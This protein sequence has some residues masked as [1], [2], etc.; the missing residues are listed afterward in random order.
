[1]VKLE[2]LKRLGYKDYVIDKWVK[3][4]YIYIEDSLVTIIDSDTYHKIMTKIL[5]GDLELFDEFVDET[6]NDSL[7]DY[8]CF[9]K[10]ILDGKLEEAIP[11]MRRIVKDKVF[12]DEYED[13]LLYVSIIDE[14]E[15]SDLYIPREENYLIRG[16]VEI[17][18]NFLLSF[19]YSMAR[20][21][22][23][24]IMEI[25][26]CLEYRVI[27]A[28]LA[29]KKDNIK[30]I[31]KEDV[32]PSEVTKNNLK[33]IERET[34]CELEM[35]HF[36]TFVANINNLNRI[37]QN[38]DCS[39]FKV[40]IELFNAVNRMK[41]DN[42]FVSSRS[43]FTFHGNV[44]SVLL[45]LLACQ[46][47]YRVAEVVEGEIEKS[48]GFDIYLVILYILKQEVMKYNNRNMKYIEDKINE[49]SELFVDEV[50]SNNPK[51]SVIHGN[52]LK[53]KE[54]RG[55]RMDSNN[56]K[57][58]EKYVEEYN[59]GKYLDARINLLRFVKNLRS[60]GVYPN[61]E[62]LFKELDYLI[63]K[64]VDEQALK[65]QEEALKLMNDKEYEKA[66]VIINEW[67][68]SLDYYHP[69]AKAM[70]AKCYF[71]EGNLVTAL[72]I[73]LETDKYYLYPEYY[74][75]IITI[76]YRLGRL[77]EI[78][79]YY[80][81]REKYD[82]ASPRIIYIMSIVELENKHY[83]KAKKLLKL[84]ETRVQKLY[85]IVP[86]Y[87][88][89]YKKIDDLSK[90]NRD[91]TYKESDYIEYGLSGDE[92][93][94]SLIDEYRK[95]YRDDYIKMLII[96]IKN[97]KCALNDKIAYLLEVL[98]VLKLQHVDGLDELYQYADYLI[99][100]DGLTEEERRRFTIMKKN[101]QNI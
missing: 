74:E 1:M 88:I 75:D 41:H 33:R 44:N 10:L 99:L 26:T 79:H 24:K 34:I 71:E 23:K 40:I 8:F 29:N 4:N 42:M 36:T 90:G 60:F 53:K 73:F 82:Y 30:Y 83:K 6:Y 58:Y 3:K 65:K 54:D 13:I 80:E 49:A 16:E 20:E 25:H 11:L 31:L 97:M 98:K 85:G 51:L 61:F 70:L 89:E 19:N 5:E 7:K 43:E 38:Q 45:A 22:L 15:L 64:P 46:D 101:Y 2:S 66:I 67:C 27:D 12:L 77:S 93:I 14:F 86:N 63:D 76:L 62:Y 72:A 91:A 81:L 68:D 59:R 21:M 94:I 47:Y 39:C 96:N 35:G 52:V 17:F 69:R 32:Y 18:K 84:L 78:E 55:I 9:L 57:Y 92:E 56:I 50:I 37:Y 87:A 28:I 95:L 100:L 48:K